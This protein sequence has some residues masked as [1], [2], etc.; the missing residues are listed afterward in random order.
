MPPLEPG[1]IVKETGRHV[2]A[3]DPRTAA[4]RHTW[5]TRFHSLTMVEPWIFAF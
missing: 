3:L 2:C 1:N 4:N 5:R